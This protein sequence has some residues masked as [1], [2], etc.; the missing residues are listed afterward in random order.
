SGYVHETTDFATVG[1]GHRRLSI[2]DLSASGHQPMSFKSKTVIFNGEIYNYSEIQGELREAGYEFNSS[3]DTEVILKAFDKWGEK[4]ADKFVGMFAFALYDKDKQEVLIFRDRAGVKPLYFYNRNGVIL[5]ASE[6]KSFHKHRSFTKE[7]DHDSLALFLQYNYIPTPYCI[8]KHTSKLEPGHFLKI[9][10]KTKDVDKQKYWDV[11]DC[12]NQPKLDIS[13]DEAVDETEKLLKKAFSYRMVADVPVGLFL[14]G[15]YDSTAVAAILQSQSK[16][17]IKTF[18]I[19]YAESEFNEADEAQKVANYIGTDHTEKYCTAEDTADILEK[20]P[21]IYDEPFADNSVVPTYLVSQLAKSQVKVALSGDA[22]DE[23]FAGY[24]KFN[25]AINF[26]K[27]PGFLQSMMSSAMSMI[28]SEKVPVLNKTYNFT[29]RYNK[30]KEIWKH[31][32][33]GVA[34]KIIS[35]FITQAEAS[36]FLQNNFVDRNTYFDISGKLNEDNDALNKLLAIDYKT[37]LLDNNLTKVDRATM[38]V[39]L[40]GRE[41][42]LDHNIL[43]FASRLPSEYKIRNGE[44]KSILKTIVHR[45]VPKEIMERPKKPFLAPLTVWFKDKLKDYYYEYLDEN[46]LKQDGIFT[47]EILSLRNDYMSGKQVNHQKL[48]NILMF[49][50]WKEKWL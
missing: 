16:S 5:F 4:A 31:Q 18:T 1:L 21:F 14:S 27:Y 36:S 2:I 20:L 17:K 42:I 44:N 6:I 30:M 33:P 38:A 45:Y 43:E 46:K 41:P 10:L 12:Y 3:S 48:W 32:D 49:Q 50:M 19:G 9:N 40:E 7:M 22:G 11:V 35:Q 34:M 8:F 39:G 37:F 13:Y 28:P 24:D 25:R 15:G 29:T 26:T 47:P 23:I